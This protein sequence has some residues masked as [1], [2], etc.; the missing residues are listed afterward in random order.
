MGNI[1][2]WGHFATARSRYGVSCINLFARETHHSNEPFRRSENLPFDF[3]HTALIAG[4]T[5]VVSVYPF[6]SDTNVG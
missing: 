3:P 5:T 4:E 1:G 6:R 2:D